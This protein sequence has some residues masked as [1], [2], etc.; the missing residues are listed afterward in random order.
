M[1]IATEEG[2][3]PWFE[4]SCLILDIPLI[5]ICAKEGVELEAELVNTEVLSGDKDALVQHITFL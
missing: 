1:I 2:D 3:R 4:Y 5:S